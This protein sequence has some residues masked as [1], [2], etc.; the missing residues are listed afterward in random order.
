[1]KTNR[2]L[3]L[4]AVLGTAAASP[5]AQAAAPDYNFLDVFYQNINDPASSGFTSDHALGV[6]GSYAFTDQF[7]G[8]ASYAHESADFNVFGVSGTASGNTYEAGIGYRFPLAE[9]VDLVPNLSY[10]S[11]NASAGAGGFS[12]STSDTGYDVGVLLRAMVTDK[13]ELDASADHST[14]GTA[15][16]TVGVAAL[17]N[18]APSFAVGVGYGSQTANSQNTNA[19]SLALRY[20]FK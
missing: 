3:L 20:Y 17:Y 16:N 14:P 4:L 15:S 6:A 2:T 8:A 7:I 9:N 1:M 19:W 12:N 18:F 11:E 5:A 13:F 10:V